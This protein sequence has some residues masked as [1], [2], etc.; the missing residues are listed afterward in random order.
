MFQGVKLITD[1][2]DAAQDEEQRQCLL[3]TVEHYRALVPSLTKKYLVN[4]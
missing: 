3:Q 4:C 1:F 2:A